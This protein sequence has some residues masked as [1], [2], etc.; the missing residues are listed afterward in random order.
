MRTENGEEGADRLKAG[1][2]SSPE[3]G[4][5]PAK[6]A[7]GRE[8]MRGKPGGLKG[9][10]PTEHTEHT[11]KIPGKEGIDL[12]EILDGGRRGWRRVTGTRK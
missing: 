1:R 2:R 11:E 6:G 12:W 4:G 5:V 8:K 7:K 3:D 9:D 10:W